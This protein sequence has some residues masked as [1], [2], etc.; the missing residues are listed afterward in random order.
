VGDAAI[1]RSF[2]STASPCRTF[3]QL[4]DLLNNVHTLGELLPSY[5]RTLTFRM[6]VR[7]NRAAGGGADYDE[8]NVVVSDVGGPFLVTA[9]NTAVTWD[10]GTTQTVTWDV[11]GTDQAPINCSQVD[12]LLSLDGG[13]SF[14]ET[15][16]AG[17]PNDG[18][19]NV[20]VPQVVTT[21][22]R[23]QVRCS[24]N[25]FFDVSDSDFTINFTPNIFAD[26]FESGNTTA[27]SSTVGAP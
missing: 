2:S 11:A 19:Q 7:D 17:T 6:L 21:E 12:I 1:F 24:G 14:G 15:V 22:G 3:P 16:V 23:L 25:I 10:G 18:S 20:T 26:G 8:M 13:Q 4:S 5:A 9:P 27:W